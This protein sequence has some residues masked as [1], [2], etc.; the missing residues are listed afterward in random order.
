VFFV[1]PRDILAL[2]L[3]DW[4]RGASSVGAP[5]WQLAG[6]LDA[7]GAAWALRNAH[8]R[9]LSISALLVRLNGCQTA[10]LKVSVG[11]LAAHVAL[12]YADFLWRWPQCMADAVV[13][14]KSHAKK[15]QLALALT[16]LS[17]AGYAACPMEA[18]GGPRVS[19][20]E[21]ALCYVAARDLRRESDAWR[22]LGLAPPVPTLSSEQQALLD[23]MVAGALWDGGTWGHPGGAEPCPWTAGCEEAE[24]ARA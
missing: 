24:E 10:L 4:L 23:E 2:R 9:A 5:S 15:E 8:V 19:A 13:L 7:A 6:V 11:G 22:P 18:R 16:M 21:V 1:L 14:E 17:G 12:G 20:G 3:P